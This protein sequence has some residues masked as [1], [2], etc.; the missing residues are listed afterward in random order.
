M[1]EWKGSKDLQCSMLS[2]H[3]SNLIIYVFRIILKPRQNWS[4][5]AFISQN[6][7]V[8][9][10]NL[11]LTD[12]AHSE[13]KHLDVC[14]LRVA[15][16]C[17]P[18]LWR[19]LQDGGLSVAELS[20]PSSQRGGQGRGGTDWWDPKAQQCLLCPYW[21]TTGIPA[22]VRSGRVSGVCRRDS[23]VSCKTAPTNPNWK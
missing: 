4:V 9:V 16:P 13:A 19:I 11:T 3:S 17:C 5:S 12:P 2:L 23:L 10:C 18:W 6:V 15:F 21:D 14:S 1:V 7:N 20:L 22:V 8:E